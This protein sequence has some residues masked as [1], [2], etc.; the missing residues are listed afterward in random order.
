M[1]GIR[2]QIVGAVVDRLVANQVAG[3]NV[4]R[5]RTEALNITELPAVVVK[6][7]G[8]KL[9]SSNSGV[10]F[11]MFTVHVEVHVRGDD[12][13]LLADPVVVAI[14]SALMAEK[15]LGG[16]VRRIYEDEVLD[17]DYADSDGSAAIFV[18]DYI[19]QYATSDK[20]LTQSI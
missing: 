8:E 9:D 2:S 19:A 3:G 6:A 11:R 7:G 17:P 16:L 1:S 12:I 4:F 5:A 18:T 20:D 15:T 10:V 13:D 14:H